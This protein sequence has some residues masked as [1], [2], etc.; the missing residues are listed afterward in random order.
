MGTGSFSGV[1]RPGRGVDHPPPTGLLVFDATA[2]QWAR[3]SSFT[4]FLD[5][6]KRRT[7]VGRLLWE[8]DQ[9]VA[10]TST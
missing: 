7:T 6:T 2:P 9:L 8:S 1:M 10:E 4:T 3:A 5:Y